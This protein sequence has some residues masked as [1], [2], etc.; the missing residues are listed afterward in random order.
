MNINY[1]KKY[2]KYKNK[3]IEFK[4]K[5]MIGGS[6]KVGDRV[7]ENDSGMSGTIIEIHDRWSHTRAIMRGDDGKTYEHSLWHFR[8]ND[9]LK[10]SSTYMLPSSSLKASFTPV[11]GSSASLKVGDRVVENDSQ[12]QGTIKEIHDRWGPKHAIMRG[13]NGRI[14]DAALWHFQKFEDTL[15][16]PSTYT[17]ASSSSSLKVGDDVEVTGTIWTNSNCNWV[18]Y[19]HDVKDNVEVVNKKGKIVHIIPNRFGLDNKK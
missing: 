18:K 5:M 16:A 13:D 4:N 6:L 9:N 3:Y 15:K 10:E 8:K 19:I 11:P 17:P 1:E 2:L 12:Q 7:V 14:Y